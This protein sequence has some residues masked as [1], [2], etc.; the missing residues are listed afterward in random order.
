MLIKIHHDL[1]KHV[2]GAMNYCVK[3]LTNSTS[4]DCELCNVTFLKNAL[5]TLILRVRDALLVLFIYY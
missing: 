2:W 3:C 5:N 4:H 1:A